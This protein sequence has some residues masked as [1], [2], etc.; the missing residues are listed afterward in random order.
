MSRILSPIIVCLLLLTGTAGAGD[1]FPQPLGYVSDF[2]GI[3]SAQDEARM[4]AVI[5]EL[6]QKTTAEIAVV[7]MP[8]IGGQSE[9]LYA[10]RLFAAWGIG[11]KGK[12]NGI[13]L[14]LTLKE[15]RFRMETGYGLE[16]ILPDGKLGQIADERIMPFLREGQYG[17][18][19]LSGTLAIAGVIAADAGVQ[20]STEGALPVPPAARPTSRGFR[21]PSLL[22]LLIIFVIFGGRM[23]LLPLLLLGGLPR[24]RAGFGGGGF[25]GGGGGFGG[26]FGGFGGGMSGGGGVSRGF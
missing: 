3:I 21:L 15:R 17:K 5:A 18:G 23:G 26:G 10:N 22:I 20:L 12:D 24:G 1:D 8:D 9:E 6:K 13:L 25:G 16:G 11:T 19:L 7:T 2:A 14:F 4:T